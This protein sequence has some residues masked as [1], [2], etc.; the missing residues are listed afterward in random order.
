M[1][2]YRLDKLSASQSKSHFYRWFIEPVEILNDLRIH[3]LATEL[4]I[5]ARNI[6]LLLM[7]ILRQ[8]QSIAIKINPSQNFFNF[9]RLLQRSQLINLG[10]YNPL[11]SAKNSVSF[12]M[13]SIYSSA[14]VT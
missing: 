1:N 9:F 7:S 2:F 13:N 14:N 10:L 12:D 11:L 8:A 6:N 5:V 3:F 4:R